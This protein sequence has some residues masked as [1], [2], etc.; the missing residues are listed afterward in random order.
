MEKNLKI[1]EKFL[2]EIWKEQKFVKELSTKEGEKIAVIDVGHENT[3]FGGPDFKNARV[4]I[5]NITYCGDVEID[6]FYSD[7]RNHG[8]YL[9]KKYNKV[10]LHASL[11]HDSGHSYVYTQ[12][13][14]K[15]ISVSLNE[16]LNNDLRTSL[17]D[18]I[19]KERDH[20][21]NKMPCIELNAALPKKEKM[22]LI[23]DL[24]IS[25]F[26]KKCAKVFERLKEMTYVKELN[27]KEPVIKYELDEN[28]YNRK[29]SYE[30]FKDASVWKQVFY[31]LVFEALGY[32]KNKKEFLKLASNA[33]L[34]FIKNYSQ[35]EDFLSYIESIL[36]N[37]SGIIQQ[38]EI[39]GDEETLQHVKK[40]TE[41]WNEV[42]QQY[43]GK[44]MSQDEWQIYKMRPS[45]FPVLRIAGGVHLLYRMMKEDMISVIVN[46]VKHSDNLK[47]IAKK[48]RALVIVKSSGYWKRYYDFGKKIK[49]DVKYFIGL[50][51]A[52]E[53]IIN[54][55]L[56]FL[57]VYFEIFGDKVNAKKVLKLYINYYQSS[58][59]NLVDEV[60]STLML[61]D[62]WKRSVIYQ[63]MIELFREYCTHAKCM[64]CRIGIKVFN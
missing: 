59:N 11:N 50:S 38:A 31:E 25:R 17:Q 9:N 10:I 2:Y 64:E 57:S 5:G 53:I 14:R 58:D 55:I 16:F 39:A 12:E 56:P 35:K 52:D 7:W 3:E 47:K 34:S 1:H 20:R 62:L 18:A 48:L 63:G 8:H 21:T 51:R 13:G 42:K 15:V 60:S 43:D 26:R 41:T 22:D 36:L 4:K 54:V 27:L 28:F 32:S 23:F 40:L 19:N 44:T 6:S 46:E 24:G 29:F 33:E 30:D 49:G 45:N 37:V 61:N